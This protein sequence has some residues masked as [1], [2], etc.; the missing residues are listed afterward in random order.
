MRKSPRKI[1]LVRETLLA[2]ER[3]SLD[4]VAGGSGSAYTCISFCHCTTAPANTCVYNCL[5]T[6]PAVSCANSCYPG[7]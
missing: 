6:A 1:R 3:R 2:L 5:T 4:G 7:C